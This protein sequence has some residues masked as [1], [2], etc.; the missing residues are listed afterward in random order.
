MASVDV[1]YACVYMAVRKA[2]NL[3]G[4]NPALTLRQLG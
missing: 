2:G 1:L 3:L 4:R